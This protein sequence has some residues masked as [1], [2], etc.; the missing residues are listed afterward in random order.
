TLE[1]Q[2]PPY[3]ETH[4]VQHLYSKLRPE[5]QIAITNHN[6]MPDTR[7]GLI[8]LA[9]TLENNLRRASSRHATK[10][11]CEE[12]QSKPSTRGH[13][14]G[15]ASRP[16]AQRNNGAEAQCSTEKSGPVGRR[17]V[18]VV[19]NVE[20]TC[21]VDAPSSNNIKATAILDPGAHVNLISRVF[22]EHLELHTIDSELPALAW[23]G[24]ERAKTYAAYELLMQLTDDTGETRTTKHITYAV[25]KEGPEIL[26]GN[27]FLKQEG[28][29]MDLG[30]Q[31]WRY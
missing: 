7:E 29:I 4:R 24:A 17:K 28:V 5:L 9:S 26:L 19:P 12:K 10:S 30:A 22:A 31:E 3:S 18:E 8:S 15:G 23:V 1:E 16:Q 20:R 14:Q 21:Y 13:R 11:R 25:D 27:P 2:L 6:Q